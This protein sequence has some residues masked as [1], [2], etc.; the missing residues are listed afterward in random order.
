MSVFIIAEI[1]IN[2]NGNIDIIKKLIEMA[3]NC[4]CDAVKFQKR[5]IE[6]VYSKEFLNS[7]RKSPWG[8]T[9]RDQKKGL[10]LGK[11]EY[12]IIDSYCREVGIEWFASSW[13][14]NSLRFLDQYNCAYAK[15]ASAMLIDHTFLKAVAERQKYAFISTGMSSMD[16]IEK[17]VNIFL[18]SNCPFELMHCVSTYPM[19]D[20][21]ANLRC[22]KTLGEYFKCKVGYSGHETGIAISL[23]A[24]ALGATSLE[25]H[26]TLDRSMYGSDQAASLEYAGL[27]NLVG[28]VR[29]IAVAMGDG[30][31]RMIEAEIPVAAKLRAH[32]AKNKIV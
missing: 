23:G 30:K 14:M 4:G 1:G 20:E 16:V 24:V 5:D 29:K 13:D 15:V 27:Y 8:T 21:D 28:S 6:I 3:K 31:K 17:A 10:E 22:I 7:P 11:K 9:Q 32:I 2:H 18:T 25:R 26:I 12:D 19:K